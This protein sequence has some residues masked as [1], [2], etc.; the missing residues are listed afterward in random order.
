M[1]L[2][3]NAAPVVFL[4]GS[5]V[6]TLVRAFDATTEEYANF[7][8]AVPRELDA[9][10]TVTFRV[11]CAPATAEAGKNVAHTLGFCSVADGEDFD[12]GYTDEDSGDRAV[13][14]AQDE[15]SIHSWTET[16]ANLGWSAGDVVFSRY[17]RPQ[18]SSNN[19][20]GDLY[21][22]YVVIEIPVA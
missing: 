8:F 14:A 2:E 22:I 9:G 1:G 5:N 20:G 15:I 19:L 21:V 4:S 16:V 12:G 18:A 11:A 7:R 13:E 10:G 17:S 3:A 6:K